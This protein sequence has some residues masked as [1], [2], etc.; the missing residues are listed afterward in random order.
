MTFWILGINTHVSIE[1]FNQFFVVVLSTGLILRTNKRY[2]QTVSKAFHLS[3]AALDVNETT[4]ETDVQVMLTSEKENYIICTLNK[5][6][7]IQTNLDLVLSEGDEIAFS[8]IGKWRRRRRVFNSS[9]WIMFN[10]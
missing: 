5:K 6:N 1:Y 8:C 9:K 7:C 3:H 4:V 10:F 2:S